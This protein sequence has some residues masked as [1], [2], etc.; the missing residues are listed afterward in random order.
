MLDENSWTTPCF[1][2]ERSCTAK[3]T[4][5][6]EHTDL[7]ATILWLLDMNGIR[8]NGGEGRIIKI[9]EKFNTKG[10]ISHAM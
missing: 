3:R 5:Y 6:F 4:T 2:W 1:L 7:A 9:S 8:V 10:W